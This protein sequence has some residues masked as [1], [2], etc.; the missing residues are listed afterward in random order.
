MK[1]RLLLLD[2]LRKLLIGDQ[3]TAAEPAPAQPTQPTF[4]LSAPEPVHSSATP[5]PPALAIEEL[6][7]V[8]EEI[9]DLLSS[10]D[11][12]EVNQ[13]LELLAAS[14]QNDQLRALLG[15]IDLTQLQIREQQL[16]DQTLGIAGVHTLNAVAKLASIAG[17]LGDLR[18][19]SVNAVFFADTELM[20]DLSLL[21]EAEGLEELTVNGISLENT[22]SLSGFNGLRR[23]VL[24][25]DSIDWDSDDDADCFSGMEEL[26][27]LTVASWPWG[28]LSPL[29]NCRALEHLSIRGGDL[30]NLEGI[31]ALTCLRHL[32]IE[33]CY[34]FRTVDGVEVVTQLEELTLTNV[35]IDDLDALSGLSDLRSLILETSETV[36]LSPL[37]ALQALETA[38]IDCSEARGLGA[39][40][41][42]GQLMCLKL[43]SIPD[44]RCGDTRL[45]FGGSELS[46]LMNCWKPVH[47]RHNKV[48]RSY[49]EAGDIGVFL[50]G[51]NLLECLSKQI[52][53]H[54]FR[55][56][57][58]QLNQRHG[59]QL[60]SR[61]HWPWVGTP[62]EGFS[63]THPVG[64]WIGRVRAAGAM[65]EHS[66]A[67]LSA[68]LAEVLPRSPQR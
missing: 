47:K 37:G 35:S 36:D 58:Q 51:L 62:E 68:A 39:M 53:L 45:R 17:V 60:L 7:E 40:A 43:S 20:L 28:D 22:V 15:L 16:W 30:E 66:Y 38:E 34:G 31:D 61:C 4:T 29:Q 9:R 8:S 50:L 42:C 6:P 19:V 41:M 11:W 54:T 52:N 3:P 59:E 13:G 57:L 33:G 18:R 12:E 55:E 63:H 44:C 27:S 67:E 49:A 24:M 65:S 48:C 21:A 1:K 23:L 46:N 2:L 64:Q 25:S 10:A 32:G 26:R 5:A 56:R 14:H